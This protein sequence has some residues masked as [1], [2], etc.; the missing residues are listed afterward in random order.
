VVRLGGIFAEV[1][2]TGLIDKLS[3]GILPLLRKTHHL[4]GGGQL[5]EKHYNSR[6][7]C[8][9]QDPTKAF[10]K[11][12]SLSATGHAPVI[13]G[14]PPVRLKAVR[15]HIEANNRVHHSKD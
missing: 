8:P 13:S 4:T 9:P 2:L 1:L 10:L 7:K 3:Q 14:S 12:K 6:Q 15:R 5:F 11:S